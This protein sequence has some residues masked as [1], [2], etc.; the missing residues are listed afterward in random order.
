VMNFIIFIIV[1]FFA[2][3]RKQYLPRNLLQVINIISE[4][5]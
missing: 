5:Q 4:Q 3:E 2:E 1:L